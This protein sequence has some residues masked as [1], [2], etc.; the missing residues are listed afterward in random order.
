MRFT[1]G[2]AQCCH[3]QDEDAAALVARFADEAQKASVDLLVFPESLMSPLGES[4]QAFFTAAQP[5][6]GPFARAADAIAARHGLWMVYT[7]NEANPDGK[8]FNTAV[9][10]DDAGVRRGAYRKM[11]LFDAGDK[12][13][14]DRMTAGDKLFEPV[15]TP[16]GKLGLGVCYDLRFPEMARSMV[17]QGADVLFVPAEFPS[18]NPLPP[19]T[20]HWDILVRSTALYNLTYVVAANQFGALHKDNPFGRSC[21]VDPWGTTVA[22]A[23]GRQDIVYA[24][25]DM[26]YQR[27]I[28]DKVATWVNR[29]PEVYAL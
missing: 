21:V 7:V 25:L 8:P 26:E 4:T 22:A 24:T 13:E 6:D 16:F 17:L 15:D 1:I 23:S 14:S 5:L 18:G 29:R 9:I 10:V 28:R 11:H 2:L 27:E 19:R 12:R 20:D 3:R